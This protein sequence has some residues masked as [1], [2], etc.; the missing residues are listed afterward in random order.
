MLLIYCYGV[1]TVS[2]D[3]K[4][5]KV[6]TRVMKIWTGLKRLLIHLTAA[7][8][9]LLIKEL[10]PQAFHLRKLQLFVSS[11]GSNEVFLIF[12]CA[13]LALGNFEIILN[14]YDLILCAL[15]V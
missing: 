7:E 12:Y 2:S 10:S 4:V 14:N 15:D 3:E 9:P 13:C 8:T 1:L 5:H 6:E 11:H